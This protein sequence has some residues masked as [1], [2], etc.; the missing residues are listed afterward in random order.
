M[1]VTTTPNQITRNSNRRAAAIETT[2]DQ[3]KE[4]N[5]PTQV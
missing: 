2:T 5:K 4:Q 1:K 3:S